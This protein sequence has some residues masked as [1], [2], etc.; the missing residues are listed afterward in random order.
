M[1]TAN[2]KIGYWSIDFKTNKHEHYFDKTMFVA[3][4]NYMKELSSDDKIYNESANN[5]AIAFESLQE[6]VRKRKPNLY[7]ITF[8]SCKYNHVA[9]LMSSK[10]G[11]ERPSGKQ[12]HEGEKEL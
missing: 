4:L 10:D 12:L 1:S 9:N 2:K 3:F 5:K 7:N 11:N 6:I 8:K